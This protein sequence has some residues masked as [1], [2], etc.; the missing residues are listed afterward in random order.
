[1]A[2]DVDDTARETWSLPG[3]LDALTS[4]YVRAWDA[5]PRSSF[6]DAVSVSQPVNLELGPPGL[7][8]HR[9]IIAP[10]FEPGAASRLAGKRDGRL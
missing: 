4:A 9:V 7:H 1:M 8:Y 2:D 6:G 10:G 5:D 3:E